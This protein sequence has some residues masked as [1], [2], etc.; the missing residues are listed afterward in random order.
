[1]TEPASAIDPPGAHELIALVEAFLTS[2]LMPALADERLR[3]RARVAANL[4]RIANREI[5]TL[6][7]LAVDP[8]GRAVPHELLAGADSVHALTL[9]L[10]DGRRSITDLATYALLVR[11]I[12]SKLR[13]A[14]PDAL[15][16]DVVKP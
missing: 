1:V 10:S 16:V 5:A 7:T 4:L 2:E 11:Y 12:E 15:R 3:Y 6:P 13:V 14:V 8:N 9:A